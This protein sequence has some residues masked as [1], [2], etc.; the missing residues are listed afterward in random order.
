MGRTSSLRVLELVTLSAAL[1]G[2][3]SC[4]IQEDTSGPRPGGAEPPAS[5]GAGASAGGGSGGQGQGQGQG[6]SLAGASSSGAPATAGATGSNLAGSGSGGTGG[7]AGANANA[8]S[9]GAGTSGSA[10]SG[11]GGGAAV[12]DRLLSQGKPALADSE[13]GNGE[14]PASHGNDSSAT[15]RWCAANSATGHYW[16]VNLQAPYAL[17][18]LDVVFEKAAAYRFKVEGSLDGNVWTSLLDRTNSNDTEASRSFALDASPRAQW[19]RITF[20]GLPNTTTW[21]SFFDFSIHGH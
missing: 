3:M 10:G 16:Q 19:I 17:A 6:G 13:E 11:G 5:A 8:G 21:A 4:A 9:S 18:K 20:T 1:T 12:V 14:H 15:T 7:N 2:L